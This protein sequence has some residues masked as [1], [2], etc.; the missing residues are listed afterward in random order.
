MKSFDDYTT[1]I[2]G[3]IRLDGGEEPD[4]SEQEKASENAEQMKKIDDAIINIMKSGTHRWVELYRLIERVEEEQL[5]EP[6]WH[7][8]TAWARNL[9]E[10]GHFQLR[11]LWRYR[12][13]GHFYADY[14]DRLKARGKRAKK[15]EEIDPKTGSI[16]PRNFER[17]EK[18]SGGDTH[19][20]DRLITSMIS[21]KI[22]AKELETMWKAK[23]ADG[24]MVRRTRHDTFDTAKK[25]KD[26][27]VIDAADIILALQTADPLSWLPE[28]HKNT[29]FMHDPDKMQLFAEA[30][31]YS[32]T[33]DHA[34]RIDALIAETYGADRLCDV[35]LHAIEIKVS[36]SDLMRDD[37]MEEYTDFCDYF[38]ICIPD[39]PDIVAAAEQKADEMQGT[40]TWGILAIA[41]PPEEPEENAE[42]GEISTE[43]PTEAPT[44][45]KTFGK[46]RVV[47]RP[48][49]LQGIMR[50]QTLGYI[51][52]KMI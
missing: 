47:R 12:K 22:G 2:P 14:A 30:A 50:D 7:S 18:I 24:A 39:S 1:S 44:E 46:I 13:A 15:L 37:K 34:A 38:Y 26:K 25:Q 21:G 40:Q 43:T 4:L 10:R 27:D 5:F 28:Q 11:E 32:G 19:T 3:Q 6:Q 36:V 41:T 23:K 20:A 17:I 51:V 45:N 16:S 9:A 35:I 31:V 29:T 33:T 52:H 48:G 8:L 42:A 49:R